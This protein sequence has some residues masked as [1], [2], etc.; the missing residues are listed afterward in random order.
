M[1]DNEMPVLPDGRHVDVCLNPLGVISRMNVGQLIEM[2]VGN[3]LDT[4]K[5]WLEKNQGNTQNCIKM[6]NE[7][8][9]FLDGYSDKR[10]SEK[11]NSNLNSLPEAEQKKIIQHYIKNGVR[12]IFPAFE[13]PKMEDILKAAKLVGAELES[14]LFLPKYNR[15]TINPVT[16]GIIYM[17]K[18][19]HISSIKQNTR[20]IGKINAITG[21]PTKQGK[22]KNSL[23][24]GEQ[25]SWAYL[26][27][28]H[29]GDVLKELF[30][31]NCDNTR[32]KDDVIRKIETD[33]SA[34]YDETEYKNLMISGSKK[35]FSTY[36]LVAGLDIK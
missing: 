14:R 32:I 24:I 36:A 16:W 5:H 12:M 10:L 22:G 26:A 35:A 23:R 18:L 15:K 19:E 2:H 9:T 8:F 17:L 31:V 20:T 1:P 4:T 25:D 30:T 33:G 13:T 28:Q 34:D 21:Q 7:L 11:M 27:Y 3:I 29:G 6:L